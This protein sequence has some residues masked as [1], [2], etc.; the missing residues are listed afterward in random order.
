MSMVLL[1]GKSVSDI[2]DEYRISPNKILGWRKELI[3]G[4]AGIFAQ[5]HPDIT[6]K[7]Q[8]R[9]IDA[10]EKTLADK[11][12]CILDG[13]SRKIIVWDLFPTMES[14]NIEILVARAKE[15]LPDA[16][17]R[18]IHDNGRQFTSRDFLDL[19][20]K[21]ELKE[22]STSPFHPQSN[23]KVERMHRTF[24]TE[25]VR[26]NAYLGSDDARVKMGRWVS[27]YNSERLHSAIGY[28]TPNEVR[29]G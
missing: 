7:A 26:R 19:V 12:A 25:E 27:F 21:L 29:E 24:K 9:K 15:L 20:A 28:P 5:K 8:Q 23:G 22:T 16:H 10:L 13:F 14:I 1:E 11:D 17:A 2:A 18:I 6:E 3:E 4:A